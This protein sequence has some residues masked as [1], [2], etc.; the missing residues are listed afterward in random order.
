M[1]DVTLEH[2]IRKTARYLARTVEKQAMNQEIASITA[3]YSS[4][5]ILKEEWIAD[6]VRYKLKTALASQSEEGWFPEDGGADIGYLSVSLDMLAEYYWMS[7]D[8]SVVEPLQRTFSFLSFFIHPDGSAGG[9]Y[10]SR[11]TTYFL[12]NGL[13]VLSV[14]GSGCAE[15]AIGRLFHDCTV[16]GFFMDSVDDRYLSHYVLHS[17]LRALEKREKN[18]HPSP[19]SLPDETF[20]TKL[21]P[22]AGLATFHNQAVYGI[23]STKKGGVIKL[24]NTAGIEFYL[25]C[26]YRINY[27]NG[28]VA[29]TNWLD[30]A[31]TIAYA[32]NRFTVAGSFN[33]VS[34]KTPSPILHLGLRCISLIFG[35]KIIGFLKKKIILVDKHCDTH[36]QR[37]I[38]INDT[39]I[40]ITDSIT[41]SAPVKIEKAGNMS[42]RHVASGKFFSKSDLLT[43]INEITYPESTALKMKTTILFEKGVPTVAHE[44]LG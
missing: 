42:L 39:E 21:F 16:P 8:L 22:D 19:A 1:H 40:T 41:S 38:S 12:P 10:G 33:R 24:F 7:R 32:D 3:L 18:T 28:T 13:E 20:G 26:G 9:E 25:D 43:E 11:N 17:F 30:P 27:G 14:L 31:Y 44:R 5:T 23:L 34:L 15:A 37:E 6:A 35:R 4:F 2:T 29:A 36:F